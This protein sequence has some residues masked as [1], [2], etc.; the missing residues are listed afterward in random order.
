MLKLYKKKLAIILLASLPMSVLGNTSDT[1]TEKPAPLVYSGESIQA[2]SDTHYRIKVTYDEAAKMRCVG[3][4][5][6]KSV[7][8]DSIVVFPPFSVANMLISE[9]DDPITRVQCWV[10]STRTEDLKRDYIQ[11]DLTGGI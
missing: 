6:E 4:D 8:I 1:K 7:A 9:S 10:T 3:F 2:I 5:D 11:H